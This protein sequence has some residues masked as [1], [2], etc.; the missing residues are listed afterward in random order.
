MTSAALGFGHLRLTSKAQGGLE[1]LARHLAGTALAGAAFAALVTA[2]VRAQD[3]SA[4]EDAATNLDE[5]VVTA[6]QN[7]RSQVIRGGNVGVL[8]DKAAEDVPFVVKSFNAAIILNQQP[9]TL[10]QLLDNDPSIRVTNAFGTAAEVFVMRGFPLFSDDVGFNGLYGLTPRQ[11]I[12]PELYDQVQV[13]NGASAF[14]NGAAPGGSAIGGSINVVPKRAGESPLT[15]ATLNY[16]GT[17]HFGGSFDFGRRS[18][19]GAFGIRVNG[20][21]RRGD[22]AAED[23]FRSARVLGAGLDWRGE[24]ARVALDLAYQR[25]HVRGLRHKVAVTTVIPKVPEADI[26]YAQQWQ[27]STQRDVFGAIRAEYDLTDDVM[28]YGSFGARD[29]AEKGIAING[30]NLTNA[31]TG[32]AVG[33]NAQF[34]P[35]TDNNEAADAGIRAKLNAFG[36]THEINAGGSWVDQTNRNAFQRFAAYPTN[37]Y[38]PVP[39]PLPAPNTVRGGDLSDPFPVARTNLRSVFVS[40]TIGAFDER[41]LL[42]LGLRRQT[43]EVKRYAYTQTGAIPPGGQISRYEESATTPVVGLVVKPAEGLSLYANRIQGLVQGPV[44]PNQV[45]VV[46]NANEI[47]PPFKSTQY[48]VGGKWTFGRFNT[49]LALYQTKQPNGFTRAITPPPTSGPTQIFAIDGQQRN[50]G[51]EFGI[52]GELTEGLRVIGGFAFNDAE[53]TKTLNGVNQGNKVPGVPDY[54]ANANVEWDLPY[55]PAATVTARLLRTGPQMVNQANTLELGA[56]TRLDLGARYVLLVDENPVTF[57]VGIDN[58]F[59]KRYWASAF[60]SFAFDTSL[61]QGLPRT[62]KASVSVDF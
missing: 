2:P 17:S 16:T 44:A 31:V 47:F 26:N 28:V 27:Y 36:L 29:G 48:E 7:N 57:R 25:T 34:T 41:L 52:D 11:L 60:N 13:L 33:N 12:A 50:R 9:Q 42:T 62:L 56:W 46:I 22:V 21:L 45:G 1:M 39:V 19:D 6:Q 30:V 14:L 3:S 49:S 40:D 32:D 54:T 55:L 51:I 23:E 53:L 10:G 58:V 24:R 8:G 20:A 18:D 43:I 61:L 4:P 37:I 5:I 59:N 15:R 38:N 35:R